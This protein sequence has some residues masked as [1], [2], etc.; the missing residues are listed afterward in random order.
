MAYYGTS[1]KQQQQQ[2]QETSAE[3][4]RM[5]GDQ[6][7]SLPAS[8]TVDR[9]IADA[10]TIVASTPAPTPPAMPAVETV[11]PPPT[12]RRQVE[13]R[14]SPLTLYTSTAPP[15][16]TPMP[17]SRGQSFDGGK[18]VPYAPYGRLLECRLVNT[19]ESINT[20][21]PIIA[22]VTKPLWWNRKVVIP[23]GTEIHGFGSPDALRD[24]IAGEGN[25]KMVIANDPTMANGVEM[26]VSGLA[27]DMEREQV[28]ELDG[29]LRIAYGMT[30][31]SAGLKGRVIK[32]DEWAEIKVF[33]ATLIS[34]A[35]SGFTKTQT[36]LLG[37]VPVGGD[38]GNAGLTA[39]Q[40]ALDRYAEQILKSIERDGFFVQ[41]PAG[42]TFYLYI[43]QPL[44]LREAK[45]RGVPTE[46]EERQQEQADSADPLDP[47]QMQR[48][49]LERLVK[50]KQ[51]AAQAQAQARELDNKQRNQDATQ[52]VQEL[53]QQLQ[54]L[55]QRQS[56]GGQ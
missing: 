32:S 50:Q 37:Q 7:S 46:I 43:T 21:T 11:P 29:Q 45:L 49:L 31:G 39:A 18:D 51:Q 44:D 40:A 53:L 19:V 17:S 15:Q 10:K 28:E 56:A 38:L 42:K 22:V 48:V 27:L 24:R 14:R 52:N 2:S 6:R 20:R 13:K 8:T 23:A 41:V 4:A 30:D 25:W 12:A 16:A 47:E 35:A 9:R 5:T 33:A 36:T 55:Q 1:S 26:S 54:Q 34:G 3:V